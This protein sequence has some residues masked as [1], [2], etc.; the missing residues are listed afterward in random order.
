MESRLR[1]SETAM[2]GVAALALSWVFGWNPPGSQEPRFDGENGLY[3]RYVEDGLAVHWLTQ[4]EVPGVLRAYN[5]HEL[6][7]EHETPKGPAHRVTIGARGRPL[8]LEYGA[9]DAPEGVH[10]TVI[11]E[12]PVPG[13]TPTAFD[14]ADSVYVVGDIHGEFS[15]LFQLLTN[16][17]VVDAEGAWTGGS[18]HLVLL[19]DL[20]DR[21]EEVTRLLWFLYGLEREAE[22]AGG[23]VHLVLGNH[24]VM[25]MTRDLRYVSGKEYLLAQRHL[26]EYSE[27][28]HPTRSVLGRW[29]AHKPALIRIEDVLMAHGGMSP[30]YQSYSLAEYQ[31][32]LYK[33]IHEDEFPF[34]ND[35]DLL[36]AVLKRS[37]LDSAAFFR[38][39]DFFFS[40]ESVLWYRDLVYTD[41]LGDFLDRVLDRFDSEIHV[42]GHTA[43]K[44]I[45]E[46]YDGKLIAVDMQLPASELL[47][48]TRGPKGEWIRR[49]IGVEGPPLPLVIP[50]HASGPPD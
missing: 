41:T 35:P 16:V 4:E 8:T 50:A 10:R 43:L 33:F 24:E 40:D 32:S 15:R 25:V 11:F 44:A 36:V 22:A 5:G 2:L 49:R 23:R 42:V 1:H 17:G 6:V 47:I 27:L 38:R 34:W 48:L 20:F 30:A 18:S 45:E 19:G 14:E 37:Q 46:R 28:F 3:V 21:G 29:L 26:T 39:D 7:E 9:L 13:D 12:P 31:D